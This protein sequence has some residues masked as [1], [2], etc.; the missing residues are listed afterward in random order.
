MYSFV[1]LRE[2]RGRLTPDRVAETVVGTARTVGPRRAAGRATVEPWP[3]RVRDAVAEGRDAMVEAEARIPPT[4][5]GLVAPI[6]GDNPAG[7]T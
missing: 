4:S 1:R 7:A 6:A 5:N 2:S 3:R